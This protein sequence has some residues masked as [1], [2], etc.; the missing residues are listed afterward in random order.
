MKWTSTGAALCELIYGLHA[1]GVF[2]HGAATKQEITAHLSKC[3][4]VKLENPYSKFQRLIYRNK[5]E[6]SFDQCSAKVKEFIKRLREKNIQKN[7]R[8]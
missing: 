8:R 4:S 3:F 6:T 2:N 1:M 7:L 5:D